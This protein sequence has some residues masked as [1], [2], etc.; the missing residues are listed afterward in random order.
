[1][2]N[3]VTLTLT[4]DGI[5]RHLSINPVY[6]QSGTG[7]AFIPTDQFLIYEDITPFEGMTDL[8]LSEHLLKISL[9]DYDAED[10]L[11]YLGAVIFTDSRQSWSWEGKPPGFSGQEMEALINYMAEYADSREEELN[12]KQ[13]ILESYRNAAQDPPDT[14]TIM[15]LLG[16]RQ[17]ECMV[18]NWGDYFEIL[19]NENYVCLMIDEHLNWRQTE[20]RHLPLSLVDEIGYKISSY[21][22]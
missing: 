2:I 11:L 9:P 3:P 8:E 1:M 6:L 7:G 22:E 13:E 12:S 16:D 10:N 18:N 4:S 15:V 14:F 5:D 21:Y 19:L 20:G 17:L